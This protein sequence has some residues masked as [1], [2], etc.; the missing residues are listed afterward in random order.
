MIKVINYS[1]AFKLLLVSLFT[2]EEIDLIRKE[3]DFRERKSGESFSEDASC[4]M[5][6]EHNLDTT[7]NDNENSEDLSKSTILAPFNTPDPETDLSTSE[8]QNL[9][10]NK[11]IIKFKSKLREYD[12]KYERENNSQQDNGV[13]LQAVKDP[14]TQKNGKAS[15]QSCYSNSKKSTTGATTGSFGTTSQFNGIIF[16]PFIEESIFKKMEEMGYDKAFVI[17]SLAS[18]ELQ[19]NDSFL[20][21]C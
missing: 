5:F 12:R 4:S 7:E 19:C 2:N 21:T 11:K 9:I 10:V 15:Q 20:F 13:Y 18:N 14:C 1:L 3:Y 6:T 16:H 8:I 17:N